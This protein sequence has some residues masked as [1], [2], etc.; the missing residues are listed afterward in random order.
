M[1]NIYINIFSLLHE[2][3]AK[4]KNKNTSLVIIVFADFHGGYYPGLIQ[5]LV[6]DNFTKKSNPNLRGHDN[7]NKP[8]CKYISLSTYIDLQAPF[9]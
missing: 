9:C 4:N 2:Q 1:H 5:T 7:R 3:I 6:Y 8:F